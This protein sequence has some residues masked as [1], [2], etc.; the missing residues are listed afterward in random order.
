MVDAAPAMVRVAA[1]EP[2]HE[3]AQADDQPDE[4]LAFAETRRKER[5]RNAQRE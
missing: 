2:E 3:E 1:A 5:V 4:K